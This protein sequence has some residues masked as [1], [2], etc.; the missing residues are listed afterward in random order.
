MAFAEYDNNNNNNNNNN[1]LQF[2][3]Y[4]LDKNTLDVTLKSER[5]KRK[6]LKIQVK[7]NK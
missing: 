5:I 4:S 6:I 3:V 2:I 1:L 7:K